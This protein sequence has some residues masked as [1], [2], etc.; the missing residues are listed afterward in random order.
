MIVVDKP[1]ADRWRV[2]ITVAVVFLIGLTAASVFQMRERGQD[3][4]AIRTRQ[5]RILENQ[6][7]MIERL[8]RI[9]EWERNQQQ[10]QANDE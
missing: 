5:E 4:D 8:D 3:T 7:R 9:E 2:M 1:N 6:A 10:G